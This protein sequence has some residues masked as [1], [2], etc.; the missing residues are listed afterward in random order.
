M[1]FP[2]NQYIFIST[3]KWKRNLPV[4]HADNKRCFVFRFRSLCLNGKRLVC[5]KKKIDYLQPKQGDPK[6]FFIFLHLVIYKEVV[7]SPL[8]VA[9]WSP[10]MEEGFFFHFP[11]E[12]FSYTLSSYT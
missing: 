4:S 5:E 6:K 1:F 7:T 11:M 3:G 12:V 8:L 9:F 10:L 2:L